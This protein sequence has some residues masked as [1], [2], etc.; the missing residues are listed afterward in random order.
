MTASG[1][2]FSRDQSRPGLKCTT[3]PSVPLRSKPQ[4]RKNLVFSPLAPA[5]QRRFLSVFAIAQTWNLKRRVPAR[6]SKGGR[7][8]GGSMFVARIKYGGGMPD[9]PET[10]EVHAWIGRSV[11]E[12]SSCRVLAR[13][14]WPPSPPLEERRIVRTAAQDET[15]VFCTT[16]PLLYDEDL[17]PSSDKFQ[18]PDERAS[19]VP[20]EEYGSRL[21]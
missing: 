3:G 4:S 17:H 10:G 16:S 9:K 18:F 1:L 13:Y 2:S 11:F 8:Y 7:L 6:S 21:R 20:L 15:T 5:L 14:I 12:E 19:V